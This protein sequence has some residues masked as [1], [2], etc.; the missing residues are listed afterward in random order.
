M[1]F[2]ISL[3]K[4]FLHFL[5]IFDP[6]FKIDQINLKKKSLKK[7][8]KMKANLV[9]LFRFSLINLPGRNTPISKTR[10][11]TNQGGGTCPSKIFQNNS[12]ATED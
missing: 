11:I 8:Q 4:S 12:A 1:G 6:I 5:L 2:N 7:G 10:S 3:I 9:Q